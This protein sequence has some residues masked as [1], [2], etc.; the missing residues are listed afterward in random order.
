[1]G[2]Y[3]NF[4]IVLGQYFPQLRYHYLTNAHAIAALSN[5]LNPSSSNGPFSS[6]ARGDNLTKMTRT[7]MKPSKSSVIREA[8]AAKRAQAA[9]DEADLKLE[10]YTRLIAHLTDQVACLKSANEDVKK[11]LS[12]TAAAL[13]EAKF[14]KTQLDEYVQKKLYLFQQK[15]LVGSCSNIRYLF[16]LMPISHGNNQYLTSIPVGIRILSLPSKQQEKLQDCKDKMRDAVDA[17]AKR[18]GKLLEKIQALENAA[19]ERKEKSLKG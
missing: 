1:M 16:I 13:E 18:E 15:Y 19:H 9:R 2:T 14:N 4:C 11:N 5:W 12:E 6:Q 7:E 17:H 10:T 8:L 3:I